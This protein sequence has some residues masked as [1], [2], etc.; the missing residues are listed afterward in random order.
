MVDRTQVRYGVAL[1]SYGWHRSPKRVISQ[2][3]KWLVVGLGIFTII[4]T[5]G[6]IIWPVPPGM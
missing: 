6:H 3:G 5:I 2:S 1:L 4:G